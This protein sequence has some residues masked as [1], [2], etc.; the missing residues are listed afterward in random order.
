MGGLELDRRDVPQRAIELA[1]VVPVHP[2]GGGV[3]DVGESLVG[4][5]VERQWFGCTQPYGDR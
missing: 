3:L 2:A 1:F 5:G 4:A